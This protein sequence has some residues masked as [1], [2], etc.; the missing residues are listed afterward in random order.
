MQN[1]TVAS[2][3]RNEEYA[4]KARNH[5]SAMEILQSG[6]S[7]YILFFAFLSLWF[8]LTALRRSKGH[9]LEAKE[10]L[11]LALI[12]MVVLSL[13]EIFAV[14][15]NLWHYVPGDWPMMLWPTYFA[16]ILFGFQLLK[17]TES[18]IRKI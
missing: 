7:W 4:F 17:L 6:Q 10:Q 12:G 3:S 18:V 2:T 1:G 8:A 11:S 15:T 16:A 14:S 9:Q 13:M 5:S